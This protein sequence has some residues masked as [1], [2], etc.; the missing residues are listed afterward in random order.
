MRGGGQFKVR[1]WSASISRSYRS[2]GFEWPSVSEIGFVQHVPG[3]VEAVTNMYVYLVN[4]MSV[5]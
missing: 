3:D 1:L 2:N 5:V 4:R